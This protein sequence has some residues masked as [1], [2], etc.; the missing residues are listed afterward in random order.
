MKTTNGM[1][2]ERFQKVLESL[3]QEP[4]EEKAEELEKG[5]G[6]YSGEELS[7]LVDGECC[8]DK[9]QEIRDHIEDCPYCRSH[10]MT[11]A[12]LKMG[13]ARAGVSPA[14]SGWYRY[15]CLLLVFFLTAAAIVAVNVFY[16]K[17]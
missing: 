11:I 15:G 12:S 8:D 16:L 17:D 5:E 9:V 13:A 1:E 10:C 3:E 14:K 6:C 4:G 2:Q 7:K